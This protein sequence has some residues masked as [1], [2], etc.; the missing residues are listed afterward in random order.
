MFEFFGAILV[1]VIASVV[2]YQ[3]NQRIDRRRGQD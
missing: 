2:A 3:I 1:A